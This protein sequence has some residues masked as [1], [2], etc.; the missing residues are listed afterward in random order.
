MLFFPFRFLGYWLGRRLWF[1]DPNEPKA[2]TLLED[3]IYGEGPRFRLSTG[4]LYFTDMHDKK[5]IK[6]ALASGERTLVYDDPRTCCQG[7]DG[8]P[9]DVY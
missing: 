5:V 8:Y 1:E 9:T 4:E 2:R 7:L 3:V 6:Y